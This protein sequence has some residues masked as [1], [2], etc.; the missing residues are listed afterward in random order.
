MKGIKWLGFGLA[1]FSL[2]PIVGCSSNAASTPEFYCGKG[3]YLETT[4]YMT[5]LKNRAAFKD[6]VTIIVWDPENDRFGKKW[7]PK[8]RCE[9][10]SQRFQEIYERDEF[11]Y[12][13]ATTASWQAKETPV[14]CAVKT[15]G[16]D[17]DED[18]LLF[19]LESTDNPLEVL[20]DLIEIGKNPEGNAGLLRGSET[21]NQNQ[22]TPQIKKEGNYYNFSELLKGGT[23]EKEEDQ[24][25]PLF[26]TE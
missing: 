12:V 16:A 19:T 18:D 8:A 15:K 5:K 4:A 14:I 7:T 13:T 11:K 21:E 2:S 25:K 22:D 6:D 17:C 3:K 26:S 23:V 9:E 24:G 1:V 10:V 20:D